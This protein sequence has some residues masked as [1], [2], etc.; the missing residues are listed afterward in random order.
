MFS[1]CTYIFV[2]TWH[3]EVFHVKQ[4]QCVLPLFECPVSSYLFRVIDNDTNTEVSRIFHSTPPFVY[5]PNSAGYT[6][7]AEAWN[8]SQDGILTEGSK[9]SLRIVSTDPDLPKMDD[10]P[11]SEEVT[12]TFYTKEIVD[13]CLPDR[14]GCILR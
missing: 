1:L 9:W 12:S 6:F 10:E 11:S 4:P 2:L 5:Q 3:R 7:Q 14:D 8:H 13:Y